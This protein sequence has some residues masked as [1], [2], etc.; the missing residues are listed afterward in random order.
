MKRQTATHL[1][2]PPMK[3]W[4]AGPRPDE[5]CPVVHHQAT[6][7]SPSISSQPPFEPDHARQAMDAAATTA[8][9]KVRA[10]SVN[11][12]S[13]RQSVVNTAGKSSNRQPAKAL[14]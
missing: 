5:L 12:L 9:R 14:G 13:A 4:A 1:A 2:D 8:T 7:P 3:R 10:A 11:S 6:N